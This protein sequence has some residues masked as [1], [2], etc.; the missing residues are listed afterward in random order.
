MGLLISPIFFALFLHTQVSIRNDLATIPRLRAGKER[1]LSARNDTG[2]L[3]R[4]RA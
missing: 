2:L 4:L 3:L 1:R